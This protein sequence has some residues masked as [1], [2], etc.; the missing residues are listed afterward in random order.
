MEKKKVKKPIFK[1]WWFWVLAVLIAASGFGAAGG[2]G[3]G[4]KAAEPTQAPAVEPA[5]A[6]VVYTADADSLKAL[7]LSVEKDAEDVQI[8]DDDAGWVVQYTARGA[9]WDETSLL[10]E[11][12]TAYIDFCRTAY[13]I[14]GVDSVIFMVSADGTDARGNASTFS[15]FNVEMPRET[16]GKYD[17]DNMRLRSGSLEQIKEDCSVFWV[18]PSVMDSANAEKIYYS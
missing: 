13:T 7:L 15:V 4:E 12:L 1:R 14:D 17:W 3:G 16:F 11:Q 2:S 18:L 6:A 9:T 10:R 5:E 8:L